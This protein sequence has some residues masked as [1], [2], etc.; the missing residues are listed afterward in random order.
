MALSYIKAYKLI[1]S[2]LLN[3]DVNRYLCSEKLSKGPLLLLLPELGVLPPE[4]RLGL[5]DVKLILRCYKAGAEGLVD[6]IFVMGNALLSPL[7]ASPR[8]RLV[9]DKLAEGVV[10]A[11]ATKRALKRES[12]R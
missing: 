2:R 6:V 4:L 9:I 5:S 7:L 8:G 3:D 12:L 11:L 10:K 1:G